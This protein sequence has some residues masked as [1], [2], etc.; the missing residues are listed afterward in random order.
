MPGTVRIAS[1]V[2][3][4]VAMIAFCS[5]STT[6]AASFRSKLRTET[7]LSV[8]TGTLRDIAQALAKANEITVFLDPRVDP[9][10]KVEAPKIA[11][12]LIELLNDT[13]AFAGA[14]ARP[15]GE[16]VLITPIG[17]ADRIATM[18]AVRDGE[19]LA[20]PKTKR[21]L[22]LLRPRDIFL[23][24]QPA[25]PD[26]IRNRIEERFDIQMRTDAPKG[27]TLSYDLWSIELQ[28]V[29][30]AQALACLLVPLGKGFAWTDDGFEIAP[31]PPKLAV[32]RT[33]RLRRGIGEQEVY[34]L[35]ETVLGRETAPDRLDRQ[36]VAFSATLSQHERFA[37]LIAPEP[38]RSTAPASKRYTLAISSQPAEAVLRALEE[39][40]L[41]FE[42]DR[43]ALSA[44]GVDL[45]QAISVD[46]IKVTDFELI[47]EIAGQIGARV[48][49]GGEQPKIVPK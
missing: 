9:R 37:K 1:L 40:G 41:N 10:A 33:H 32:R 34:S 3:I 39:Q 44:A 27:D 16:T 24:V 48:E 45:T 47:S 38:R 20:S 23:E 28:N 43:A 11:K 35:I 49:M 14:T 30:A 36:F 6:H 31:L 22:S 15:I 18:A 13:A 7:K 17:D 19:L 46:V 8:R 4:V 2:C 5:A 26:E 21:A 29:T 25:T 42:W 12:P